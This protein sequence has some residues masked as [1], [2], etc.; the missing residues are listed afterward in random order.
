[1]KLADM[2]ISNRGD[3]IVVAITGEIDMSNVSELQ[4]AV[5]DATSNEAAGL[6]LDLSRLDYLDSAG[7]QLLFRLGTDLATRGQR[8]VLVVAD[9]S[10]VADTFR[11]AGVG[12]R[13]ELVPTIDRAMTVLTAETNSS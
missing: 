4:A 13:M 5:T 6:A 12:G 7:I 1:M 8:F 9:D 3:V 2:Q 10:V 11:L